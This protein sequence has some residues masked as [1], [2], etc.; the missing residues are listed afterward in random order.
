MDLFER[1]KNII[2]FGAKENCLNKYILLNC[3]KVLFYLDN[4]QYGNVH[5][6]LEIRKPG[7]WLL[8]YEKNSVIIIATYSHWGEIIE[9]LLNLGWQRENIVVALESKEFK[10]YNFFAFC[11]NVDLE[12]PVPQILNLELSGYCNLRCIYCPFHG[13][14]N[15][16][17]GHRGLMD[18]HVLEGVVEQIKKIKSIKTLDCTGPGEI[19]I[20]KNWFE[21]VQYIC[22]NTSITHVIVYTNG[23]LL[24]EENIEK[25]TKINA[26][27]VTVEVS[28]D[29]ENEQENNEYRVGADYNVV[30]YN[31]IN[32]KKRFEAVSSKTNII[33]TNCYAMTK[34]YLNEHNR[35]LNPR[36]REVPEFLKKDFNNI[37]ITSQNLYFYGDK[38]LSI[39]D[40]VKV[41]WPEDKIK[42]LNLFNRLAIN[43]KG[44]LLRCSCGMAGIEAIANYKSDDLLEIWH[45]NKELNAARKKFKENSSES[46]FCDK[47]P[48]S[49]LGD[50]YILT[51]KEII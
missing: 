50:Y 28:I 1:K 26:E 43:Y 44:D 9:Q 38:K 15:L 40:E 36:L 42:C 25:L 6:G 2:I 29:G 48:T 39:F 16:K 32:A 19:F 35:I 45:N 33:I 7:E 27:S 30:R 13:E 41:N 18:W 17:Q 31:V 24:N 21:M 46:I 49:G 47:C 3:S 5:N 51:K 20:N 8:E 14:L 23:M 4:A 22:N 34:Q 10:T 12:K 37:E 11:Y